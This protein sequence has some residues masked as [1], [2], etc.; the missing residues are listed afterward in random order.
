[1]CEELGEVKTKHGGKKDYDLMILAYFHD[2]AEAWN[3]LRRV[4]SDNSTVCFV[5]GD[6]APYGVHVPVEQWL[7]QLALAVGFKSFSFSKIR[8]RNV[9]WRN[10]KHTV[11]LY[12]GYLWVRG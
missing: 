6:S 4:T 12:E 10:R 9:K 2:M 5:I 11:P 8:D 7:A 3:S 1:M